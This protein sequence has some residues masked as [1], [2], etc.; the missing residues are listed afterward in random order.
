MV[1]V[2]DVSVGGGVVWVCVCDCLDGFGLVVCG[3]VV[4]GM[5]GEVAVFVEADGV[6]LCCVFLRDVFGGMLGVFEC[7]GC[8]VGWFCCLM[9]KAS[10]FARLL[11]L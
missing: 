1:V 8:F 10:H 5:V 9:K 2:A 11:V 6:G 3:Y 4:G 7:W